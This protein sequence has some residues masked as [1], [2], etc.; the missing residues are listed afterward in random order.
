M[1]SSPPLT[2]LLAP[3]PLHPQAKCFPHTR[4]LS[5]ILL[6]PTATVLRWEMVQEYTWAIGTTRVRL[7][8]LSRTS[9][10]LD[11]RLTL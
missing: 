1:P 6:K 2:F 7:P 10:P 4:T 8:L 9:A 11:R 3:R 5:F